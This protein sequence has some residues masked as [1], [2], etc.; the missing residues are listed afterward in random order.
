M[1]AV[2]TNILARLLMVDDKSQAAA[3]ARLVKS[4]VYIPLTV[5]LEIAWLLRSRYRLTRVETAEAL[6]V[7]LEL[8]DVVIEARDGIVWA[9][10][11]F[12]TRGDFADFIHLVASAQA[13]VFLTFDRALA[14]AAGDDGPVQVETVIA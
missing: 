8:P 11:R 6:R 9:V 5:F 7:L 14:P 13:D 4:G 10:N 2:D 3:A 12:E 1:K